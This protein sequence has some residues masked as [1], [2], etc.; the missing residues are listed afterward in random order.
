MI[1][2]T[3]EQIESARQMVEMAW[4][5]RAAAQG[6]KP[7]TQKY[8][9]AELEFFVGAMAMA[10]ALAP[11]QTGPDRMSP[12]PALHW[13]INVMIGRPIVDIK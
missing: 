2:L 9:K 11:N 10:Q 6:L 8:L 1:T 12:V 4:K 13:T 7:G 5:G 3:N